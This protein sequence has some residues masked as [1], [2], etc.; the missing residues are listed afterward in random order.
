M[1][2]QWNTNESDEWAAMTPED[3]QNITTMRAELAGKFSPSV[4]F[5]GVTDQ[6]PRDPEGRFSTNGGDYWFGRTI[7]VCDGVPVAVRFWTSAEFAY[8]PHSGHFGECDEWNCADAVP[9]DASYV[10]GWQDGELLTGERHDRAM[11]RF[12]RGSEFFLHF[13]QAVPA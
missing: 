10:V 4:K 3:M 9:F 8:C 6:E 5:Y 2:T 13:K 7:A 1:N 11:W 12:E